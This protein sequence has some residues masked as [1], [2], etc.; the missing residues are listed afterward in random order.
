MWVG[1]EEEKEEDG[2]FSWQR[3]PMALFAFA[4]LLL[5][6]RAGRAKHGNFSIYSV[7]FSPAWVFHWLFQYKGG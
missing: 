1:E 7:T 2:E 4:R 6:L 3:V 5:A